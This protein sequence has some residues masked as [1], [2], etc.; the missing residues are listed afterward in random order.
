MMHLKKSL[1]R[2]TFVLLVTA[3]LF[4]CGKSTSPEAAEALQSIIPKPVTVTPTGKM[5][6]LT[7]AS[8]VFVEGESEELANIAR[9]L[10]SKINP[11]TGF[12]L[13]V[14]PTTGVPAAGNIYLTLGGDAQLGDEGYQLSITEGL[15][16]V[17]ANK[18]AGLFRG[19]QTIRQ[20]FPAK[21]ESETRQDGPWEIATAE[22]KDMPKYVHR[23]SMLDVARHFFSIEDV[24]RYI[25]LLSY[26]KMNVLHLHLSDDQG[27][28]IEIKSW[29]RLATHGG[30]TQV[31]GGKGGYY[32]QEQF[33]DLVA[34]AASRYMTIIPEIDLPGH[35]NSALA[36]YGE[37][38]NGIMVPKEGRIEL[39]QPIQTLGKNKPTELYTG[40]HVGFST[41][42]LNK[43]KTFQFVTDVM[44][45]LAEISPGPYLHVGGDEA[46][47]TKKEDYIKFIN[48]FVE[49]VKAQGK[50]MVG[51]E[52]ISQ[53]N[54]G[55]EVV[56]QFWTSPKY[57]LLAVEKG[58]KLIMS[59]SKKAYMDMQYD[60]T[61]RLGLHWAAY[62]EVDS[63]Y[64]WD[65]ENYV[66]G[67]SRENILGVEAPLW[68]E[69]MKN[70]DDIEYLAFPRIP[71]YAEIGW[72]PSE[73]RGWE[74]YKVRLGSHG[75]RLKAMQVDYYPS[76]RVPW[77]Q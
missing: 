2:Y 12:D 51:W 43:E 4:S 61:S 35:T 64:S 22:I 46:H 48:Q 6:V 69:T 76:K 16:T 70:M 20:L 53:G 67:I 74:E 62:I 77:K 63:A 41:L 66:R 24:K 3:I 11:S 37:L 33:K 44:R 25:D 32:T 57:A 21:I 1:L 60:S 49:I 40:M 27:W 50:T 10:T 15:V 42:S 75:P 26:Y 36:S 55:P 5:F 19:V 29:P 71:G 7:D 17:T 38:N 73:N 31:G 30:T 23:G 45:E 72:S 13:S 68:S 14:T 54:I 59:P 18:A 8:N 65:P 34:F 52:E 28:R 47:V 58:S 9:Y 39:D 56:T